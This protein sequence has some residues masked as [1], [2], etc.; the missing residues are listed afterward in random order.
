MGQKVNPI[1][2]RIGIV[3]NWRSRWYAGK[4]EYGDFVVEDERIRRAIKGKYKY[5]AIPKIEIERSLEEVRVIIH[6]ARPG[7]LIGKKGTEVEQIRYSMEKLTGKKVS[8][9]VR[10]V[11]V[12]EK[13]AQLV[14]EEIATQLARRSSPRRTLK[15]AAQSVMDAGAAGVRI[16]ISGRIGGSEMARKDEVRVGSVPLHTLTAKIDYGFDEARTQYGQ[17]GVK[18]WIH[19]KEAEGEVS[20]AVDA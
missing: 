19:D 14:A 15:K 20:D 18:V 4:K 1:G 8:V 12:P 9:D 2:L 7:L 6:S 11:M 5:A 13:E 10:E 16:K 3:E 17:I